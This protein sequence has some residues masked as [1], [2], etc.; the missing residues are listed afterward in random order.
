[1]R[2]LTLVPQSV[3][4]TG[5]AGVILALLWFISFGLALVVHYCCGW[6]IN[7]SDGERHFSQRIC[8]I[9]LIILTCA[10]A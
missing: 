2:I 10:A 6:K 1:M 7:I 5:V 4:F 9:V 8:L 3:G